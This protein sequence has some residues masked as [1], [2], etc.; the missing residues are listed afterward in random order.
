MNDRKVNQM[1]TYQLLTLPG[2]ITDQLGKTTF[3]FDEIDSTNRYLKEHAADCPHGTAAC[4]TLQTEGRGRLGKQWLGGKK[5]VAIS[6]L[7]KSPL[8]A[9]ALPLCCGIGVRTALEKLTGADFQIKW[10]NDIICGGRKICGILCESRMAGGTRSVIC[11][12]GVNLIYTEADFAAAGLPYATSVLAETGQTLS[13]EAVTAE[14]ANQLEPVLALLD[15]TGFAGIRPRY[16]QGCCTVGR[17]V[18]VIEN[19]ISSVGFAEDITDDGALLV[20][21]GDGI[22]PVL[23]GEASVR[24]LYGYI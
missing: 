3:W 24:G 16:L 23:A 22:R 18:S 21:F 11:G 15:Q 12:I 13:P 5:G 20:R 7:I 8:H 19:G 6:F 14:I 17:Q 1:E 2:L 10:P 4:T 9:A